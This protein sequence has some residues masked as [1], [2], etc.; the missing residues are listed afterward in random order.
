MAWIKSIKH[1]EH[2]AIALYWEVMTVLYDHQAQ[3][4][5]LQAGGWVTKQDYD[6]GMAPLMVR[7]WE[8]PSGLAPELAAG[9]VAFISGFAK[10]QPEFEGWQE[11]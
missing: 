3:S 9:A 6:D 8:I 2:G 5:T 11:V 10:Q 1:P 7:R 4:S